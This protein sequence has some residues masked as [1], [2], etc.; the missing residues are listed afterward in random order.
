MQ[1]FVKFGNTFALETLS[2]IVWFSC[3]V[4][5]K[6]GDKWPLFF[7]VWQIYKVKEF[8]T[9]LRSLS[10]KACLFLAAQ[11]VCCNMIGQFEI[12]HQIS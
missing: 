3:L 1:F 6:I 9:F 10:A 7:H 4:L 12:S 8:V 11:H 2:I 5:S